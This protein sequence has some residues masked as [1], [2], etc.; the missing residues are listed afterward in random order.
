MSAVGPDFSAVTG[1]GFGDVVGAVLTFALLTAVATLIGS[2]LTW[3]IAASS[4]SWQIAGK[5]RTGVLV[6]LGGAVLTG[7]ALA[8][9][10]WLLALGNQL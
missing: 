9:G 6:A 5:A 4:G 1:T 10:E 8:W 3:A 7:G 2:A